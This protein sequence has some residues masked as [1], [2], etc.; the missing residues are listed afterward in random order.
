M[1]LEANP[2]VDLPKSFYHQN[3]DYRYPTISFKILQDDNG[4]LIIRNQYNEVIE[5]H[6]ISNEIINERASLRE[7][8]YSRLNVI[9]SAD[10]NITLKNIKQIEVVLFSI[11]QRRITYEVR[12]ENLLTRSFQRKAIAK[13]I[14]YNILQFR[15]KEAS[16][17][18]PFPDRIFKEPVFKDTLNVYVE[19]SVIIDG[20]KVPKIMLVD[21]FKDN[22]SID[23]LINYLISENTTYQDYITV[24]S[25]HFK[26]VDE[27]QKKEQVI[28]D[29][30]ELY[31]DFMKEQ[32]ELK[33][34]FPIITAETYTN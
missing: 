24:L 26:A 19:N 14:A 2:I 18:P 22:V 20:V 21:K 34:K 3:L 10:K 6:E 1:A 30:Y 9:V 31:E 27:L 23:I 8:L 5:M 15:P 12:N 7:E 33:L 13:T 25:A 32:S 28:E 16:F 17:Y 11:G 4:E 29:S